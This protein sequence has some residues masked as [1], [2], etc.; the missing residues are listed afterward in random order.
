MVLS[1]K[2]YSL[3][4]REENGNQAIILAYVDNLL[5]TG[6]DV[7]AIKHLE[8]SLDNEFT[9]KDLSE[10]SF[11]LG[12]EIDINGDGTLLNQRKYIVD[13]LK[14]NGIDNCKITRLPFLEG[15]KLSTVSGE[16]LENPETYRRIIGRLLYL[17]I[18]R[19]YI[20][21]SVQQLSRFMQCP[22]KPHLQ[23]TLHAIKYLKGTIHWGLF[24]PKTSELKVEG[25]SNEDWGSCAFSA[26]FL[27]GFCI[28]IGRSIVSW[29]TKKQKTVSKSSIEAEYR[30][31]S[32]TTSEIVWVYD[33]LKTVNGLYRAGVPRYYSCLVKLATSRHHDKV[34]HSTPA[35]LS[36]FQVGS[37]DRSPTPT[38]LFTYVRIFLGIAVQE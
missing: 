32:H 20:S 24:Y 34:S 27:T 19:P 36:L 13:I 23:E 15:M 9:I 10:L 25:Y 30:S 37:S 5:I 28:F 17:N 35:Q 12:T 14:D 8:L 29:K 18:T 38:W 1:K 3:F 4:T 16:V 21:F 31:M 22:R 7:K 11:F 33:I 2:Y 26:K 6:Y